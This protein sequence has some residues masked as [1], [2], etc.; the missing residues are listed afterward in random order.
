MNATM[1]RQ[2]IIDAGLSRAQ[3]R[4]LLDDGEITFND[5]G[6][7]SYHVDNGAFRHGDRSEYTLID[8]LYAGL[9]TTWPGDDYVQSEED[10]L[11]FSQDWNADLT[12]AVEDWLTAREEEEIDTDDSE[13]EALSQEQS[14]GRL[15]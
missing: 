11:E 3:V 6:W 14:N 15:F 9:S 12:D 1:R 2:F 4:S 10:L 8:S 7:Y 5:L 13:G